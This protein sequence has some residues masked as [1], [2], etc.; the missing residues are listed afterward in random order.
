MWSKNGKE[1]LILLQEIMNINWPKNR[2]RIKVMLSISPICPR[3]LDSWSFSIFYRLKTKDAEEIILHECSHFLYFE[4]WK[5][6]Y[7]KSEK[8]NFEFPNI[9]WQLSELVTPIILNDERIQKYL[10]RKARFYKEHLKIKMGEKTA[11]G[12]L[13]ELYKK[14]IKKENGFEIFLEKANRKIRQESKN[15]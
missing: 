10:K 3:F 11:P 2:K 13:T 7:P 6:L 9:E 1:Y 14:N 5:N 8:R 15:F 12:F 4:K